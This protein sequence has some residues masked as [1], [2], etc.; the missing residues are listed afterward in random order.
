MGSGRRGTCRAGT[1]SA[2]PRWARAHAM[3]CRSLCLALPLAALA[4]V[5]IRSD[6]PVGLLVG[7]GQ[8][9]I[10]GRVFEWGSVCVGSNG[11]RGQRVGAGWAA[12]AG[13]GGVGVETD[14][15]VCSRKKPRRHRRR[16][17]CR[18]PSPPH[19]PSSDVHRS[20]YSS[21]T[22][23]LHLRITP[24]SSS[25]AHWLPS[26]PSCKMPRSVGEVL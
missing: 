26:S 14:Q 21:S 2:F 12:S 4:C 20:R 7:R 25:T 5:C 3:P 18:P 24:S 6:A 1:T 8:M 19:L 23:H 22:L 16:R 9:G 10:L 15:T 17:R 11:F 13:W